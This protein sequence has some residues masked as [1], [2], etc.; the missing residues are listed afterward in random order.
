MPRLETKPKALANL[1]MLSVHVTGVIMHGVG[2]Y[3]FFDLKE[4]GHSA[5]LNLTNLI[6]VLA[7]V[8]GPLKTL[9]LQ[10]CIELPP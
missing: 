3:G 8:K 7:G 6:T 5:N 1:T 9:Y 4:W 10:V 2:A